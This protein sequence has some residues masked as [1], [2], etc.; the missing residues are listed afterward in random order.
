MIKIKFVLFLDYG[1]FFR[2]FIS[3]NHGILNF[4]KDRNALREVKENNKGKCVIILE[5]RESIE[6]PLGNLLEVQEL[7]LKKKVY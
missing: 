6:L 1:I 5:R 7:H 4:L 2:L 3:N